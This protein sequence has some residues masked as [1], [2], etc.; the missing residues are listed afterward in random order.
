MFP[1]LDCGLNLGRFRFYRCLESVDS[2]LDAIHQEGDLGRRIAD[3]PGR[4]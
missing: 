2:D 4:P 1:L 3:T